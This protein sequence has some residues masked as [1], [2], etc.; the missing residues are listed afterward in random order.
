M[1]PMW[2]KIGVAAGDVGGQAFALGLVDEVATHLLHRVRR[3][4]RRRR[5]RRET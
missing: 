2:A 3:Q 1:K 4:C 5:A